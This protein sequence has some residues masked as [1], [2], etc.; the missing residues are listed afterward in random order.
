MNVNEFKMATLGLENELHANGRLER[1]H[2][3]TNAKGLFKF[4]FILHEETVE[5]L[6]EKNV[7]R[8]IGDEVFPS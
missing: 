1:I 6:K 4:S 5:Y 7:I 2:N 3:H 8:D